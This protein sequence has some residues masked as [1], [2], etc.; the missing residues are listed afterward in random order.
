MFPLT[1]SVCDVDEHCIGE[2]WEP[3]DD[4][5]LA[6]LIA[7]IAMGQ[8]AQ[9]A[10]I[11]ESMAPAE[12]AFSMAELRNE[13]KIT[14]TVQSSPQTPR[15]GYPKY[16][17]DGF[18]FEAISW[19]AAKQ[20]YGNAA[21]LKDPH[22]SSTTQ[23]L[24]GLMLELNVGRT[25]IDRTTVF[26]DK[27]TD[28]PVATF[29]GKVMTAFKDR[30]Q[31]KRSAEIIAAASTLLRMAGVT[32]KQAATMSAQVTSRGKR[33]YRAAFAVTTDLDSQER[34]AALFKGYDKLDGLAQE[35]RLGACFV[36]PP[37]LRDWLESLSVKAIHFLD[38]LE[39][40]IGV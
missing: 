13:A 4:D 34:R 31:N 15:V 7:L 36:V 22:V 19:L 26:E 28:D 14:L 35:Q 25:S 32:T 37:K 27:C 11:I 17:R 30:H 12:P 23:G 10:Y 9:A 20:E 16:Q 33:R 38:D 6:A 21:V 5:Q 18:I 39:D 8:A 24:D 40:D 3:K 2:R 29:A 1:T